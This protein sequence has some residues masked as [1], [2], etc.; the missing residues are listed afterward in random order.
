MSVARA[1]LLIAV[2]TAVSRVLGFVREAVYAAVF[3][4]GPELDA[5]LVAQGPLNLVVTLISSAVVTTAIPVLSGRLG[6]GDDAAARRTFNTL[7]TLVLGALIAVAAVLAAAAEPLIELTAPGFDAAQVELSARLARVLLAGS[8]F[9]AAMNL[10]AGLLQAHGEF[11]WPA[12]LGVPFNVVMIAAAAL[13]GGDA[14]VIALAVGF[15]LGSALRVAFEVPGLRRIRFRPAPAF[16]LRDPGLRTVLAM[17]PLVLV[18]NS[19]VNVNTFVDRLVGSLEGAGTISA[20]SYGFRLLTLPHGLLALALLQAVYPSFGRAASTGER[21]RFRELTGRGLAVLAIA[22]MPLAAA[23]IALRE[24]L[25][26]VVYARG[27]FDAADVE[28]TARAVAAFAPCW[29]CS[30]G[31]SWSRA[32]STRSRTRACRWRPR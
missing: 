3:G 1:A 31:A 23:C 30:A 19:V 27:S 15:V 32:P 5:F 21:E 8:A 29:C 24:P 13:F 14:G 6:R 28:L 7:F 10:L 20:L 11:F 9:V 17:A 16:D 26:E 12:V 25:V 22:L 2:L 4:A 18:G